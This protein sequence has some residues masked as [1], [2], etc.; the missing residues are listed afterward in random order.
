MKQ[1]HQATESDAVDIVELLQKI[2]QDRILVFIMIGI[3]ATIGIIF[4]LSST[5]VYSATTTFIPKGQSSGA[6]GSSLSGLASLAG[7]NLGSVSGSNSEIPSS[8]YPMIL[9]SIPFQKKILAVSVAPKGQK[10]L[11]KEHLKSQ[12][13]FEYSNSLSLLSLLKK[14]TLGLPAWV[15]GKL[16]KKMNALPSYV[17]M[18]TIKRLSYEDEELSNYLKE[19]INID[20]NEE[21]GFINITY[22]DQDPQSAAIIA[23]KTQ[24]L[25]QEEVINF[26]IKN[27]QELL[28]FTESLKDEKKMF[29]EALQDE[30]ATFRDQHQ[31]ISSGIFKNK[32][33]RLESELAIARSVYEELAKQVEQARIQVRKDTPIFT[34]IDP[35]VIPNQ[36]TSPKRTMIVVI[37]SFV[38]LIIGIAYVLIKEPIKYLANSITKTN[39]NKGTNP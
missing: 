19:M 14:Y 22:K 20:V 30:L 10:I 23:L 34:I 15:K 8:M 6:V 38:G 36:R 25:L 32:L 33:S 17:E 4:A 24:T 27:A 16:F 31:N 21:E 3:F 1:P 28:T 37:Y 13:N 7:I 39:A 5:N 29:F 35:V 11:F 12:M 9:N 18:P 26:K 2:W